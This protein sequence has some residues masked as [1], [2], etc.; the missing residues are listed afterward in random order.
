VA[1]SATSGGAE[2]GGAEGVSGVDIKPSVAQGVGP[3][4]LAAQQWE[5]DRGSP[6][7]QGGGEADPPVDGL[8]PVESSLVWHAEGSALPAGVI[9]VTQPAL[10]PPASPGGGGGRRSSGDVGGTTGGARSSGDSGSG[11]VLQLPASCTKPNPLAPRPPL[12]AL[13]PHLL[14]LHGYGPQ[15]GSPPEVFGGLYGSPPTHY[16][17]PSP[18]HPNAARPPAAAP[19]GASGPRG[20]EGGDSGGAPG[21]GR[22]LEPAASGEVNLSPTQV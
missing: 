4:R 22:D 20:W 2:A 1:I 17:V 3:L 9:G 19:A 10:A 21:G 7:S 14:V 15:L 18:H 8:G 13:P 11:R 12:P 16:G 5:H 6:H